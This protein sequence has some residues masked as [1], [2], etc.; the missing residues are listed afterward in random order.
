VGRRASVLSSF[1]LL[2]DS[3]DKAAEGGNLALGS[4]VQA[5][6]TKCFKDLDFMSERR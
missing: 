6:K 4:S 5:L 2:G 1:L 3:R